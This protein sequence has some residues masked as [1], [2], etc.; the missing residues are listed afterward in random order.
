[1][2]ACTSRGALIPEQVWD[3]PDIPARELFRGK[4]SGSA[5]PLVWAHA[6]HIKLLRS[7]ADGQ[8]YDMPPQTDWSN[9]RETRAGDCGVGVFVAEL[10]T[11][12][13]IAGRSVVFTWRELVSGNW[14]GTDYRVIVV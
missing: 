3:S 9:S 14:A 6:E 8:V 1:M 2:E 13:L 4:P 10:P 7:L 5:M 12:A 11:S